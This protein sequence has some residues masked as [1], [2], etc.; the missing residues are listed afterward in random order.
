MKLSDMQLRPVSEYHGKQLKCSRI[1]FADIARR[2]GL[3]SLILMMGLG[4][5]VVGMKVI[6]WGMYD[7]NVQRYER[8]LEFNALPIEQREFV[9]YYADFTVDDDFL[10][11]VGN[12][13]TMFHLSAGWWAI[14]ILGLL[15][16]VSLYVCLLYDNERA[17]EYF[18]IDMPLDEPWAK[19]CFVMMLPAGWL[20]MLVS[21]CR[22]RYW[23]MHYA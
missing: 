20:F 12:A 21:L 18:F 5:F 1:G 23:R 3:I 9:S 17:V 16:A 19:A 2:A 10:R 6:S 7:D 13:P 22:M 14:I 8:M 4:V 11:A 15:V